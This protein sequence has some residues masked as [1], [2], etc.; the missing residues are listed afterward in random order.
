MSSWPFLAVLS[1]TSSVGKSNQQHARVW[2]VRL[3]KLDPKRGLTG[4]GG[5]ELLFGL[6][7]CRVAFRAPQCY[8][9]KW[10]AMDES[11]RHLV[12]LYIVDVT[13]D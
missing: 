13:K 3:T 11:T 4:V 2:S 6:R 1:H 5:S 12:V 10:Q 8:K 7:R 9:W